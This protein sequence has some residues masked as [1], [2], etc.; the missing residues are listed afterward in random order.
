ML[1][2]KLKCMCY[3]YSFPRAMHSVLEDVYYLVQTARWHLRRDGNSEEWRQQIAIHMYEFYTALKTA[4]EAAGKVEE[5]TGF[6]GQELS[7]T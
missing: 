1:V 6:S 2:R 7:A 3:E 4:S 5:D